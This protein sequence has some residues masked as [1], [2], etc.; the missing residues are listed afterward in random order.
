MG[1]KATTNNFNFGLASNFCLPHTQYAAKSKNHLNQGSINKTIHFLVQSPSYIPRWVHLVYKTRA[2]NCHAWAT[3]KLEFEKSRCLGLKKGS[4]SSH[5]Q[6]VTG[7]QCTN[8][9]VHEP[10]NKRKR[11]KYCWEK[12]GRGKYEMEKE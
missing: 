9:P 2:K 7:S 5:G 6:A 1:P 12:F 10:K 11:W 3:L 8:E 4:V